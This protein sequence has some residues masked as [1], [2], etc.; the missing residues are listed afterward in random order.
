MNKRL[1]IYEKEPEAYKAMMTLENY[2]KGSTIDPLL[3]EL[4]KTR[5][6]QI[7]GCAYCVDMH[8]ED[9]IKLGE[10]E[11][12]LFAL[13]VWKESHLFSEEERAVLQLTEEV[14]LLSKEGVTDETY[15]RVV[16][17]FGEQ[18]TAQLIMQIVVINAWNRIAVTTKAIYKE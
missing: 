7:N 9:A 1:S 11:R 13:S 4:I 16:S 18:Q 6:S 12:R 2:T 15:D 5:A 10:S 3:K 14:T 17:L 8:T